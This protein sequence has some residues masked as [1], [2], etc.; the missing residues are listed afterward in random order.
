MILI[1]ETTNESGQIIQTFQDGSNVIRIPK[2][3]VPQTKYKTAYSH[4]N[5]IERFEEADQLRYAIK[6]KD[7]INANDSLT[8]EE[9]QTYIDSVELAQYKFDKAT[10]INLEDPRLE[11]FLNMLVSVGVLVT[12][13]VD[14]IITPDEIIG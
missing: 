10:Y 14:E 13:T 11:E 3:E 12:T 9:K 4:L 8:E 2:Q 6:Y 5:F 1:G 7:V